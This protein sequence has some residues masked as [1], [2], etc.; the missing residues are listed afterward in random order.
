M[1]EGLFSAGQASGS[2]AVTGFLKQHGPEDILRIG[3]VTTVNNSAAVFVFD[4][5]YVIPEKNAISATAIGQAA[6]NAVS[7][8]F[9]IMIIKND[10]QTP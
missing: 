4:P 10:S 5:P 2:T 3:A 9:N 7:A 8:Y 1:T 6:N